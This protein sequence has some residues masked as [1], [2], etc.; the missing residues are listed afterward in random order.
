[1]IGQIISHYRVVE[2]LGGGGMG[3]VYKAEDVKLDRFVA[4]KFLPDDVAKDAQA[5]SRFQREAK[6]ASALNHPNICTIYE[7]DDQHGEAF[8]AMEFLDGLTLKHL[9]SGKPLETDVLMQLAIEIADALDAAHAKGIVHRDIKP[10]NIFVTERGHAKVLDF[11]LAKVAAASSSGKIAS[12]N[13]MTVQSDLTSPGSTLGTVAYMSPEQVRGKELDGRSDLF[14]FGV[15]LYEM[16]TGAQPFRGDTSA[17]IFEAIMNRV[18]PPPIRLNP[19]LPVKLEEIIL[20]ALEKDISLRYQHAADLKADLQRLK[21]DSESG[22]QAQASTEMPASTSSAAHSAQVGVAPVSSASAGPASSATSRASS[23]GKARLVWAIAGPLV[24]VVAAL[25][26]Y[27][28]YSRSNVVPFQNVTFTKVTENGN[29]SLAA[30]S[31]DGKYLLYVVDTH[32]QEGLWLR[33]IPSGSN[34]QVIASVAKSHFSALSFSPD[35]SYFYFTRSENGS[36]T[37]RFL[38]RAPVLGGTPEKIVADIDSEITFSPDGHKIA[39]I[40]LNDPV[41]GR[42]RLNIRSLD[43]GEERVLVDLPLVSAFVSP[44]WSPDGKTIIG[45]ATQ[46]TA[47]IGSLVAV[48][49]ASGKLTNFVDSDDHTFTQAVWMPSGKGLLV[50]ASDRD[51]GFRRYQIGSVS[52]PEGVVTPITRDTNDYRTVSISADGQLVS[53]VL[54][55]PHT[56]LYT[57]PGSGDSAHAQLISSDRPIRDFTWIADKQ[58]VIV[59]SSAMSRIDRNGV[60]LNL[61]TSGTF[62]PAS[63]A[64]CAD[65]H[66]L[67]FS[68]YGGSRN[69]LNLWRMDADGGKLKAISDGGRDET[70]VCSPDGRSVFYVEG[71]T[72]GGTVMKVSIEGGKAE[73]VSDLLVVSDI[74]VSPDGSS[75]VLLTFQNADVEPRLAVVSAASGKTTLITKFQK[76]PRS[77]L[78]FSHDGKAVVYATRE[79][80][81]DNLWLQPLDGSPG[82]QLTSFDSELISN[83]RWSFDGSELGVLRGH[84]DT[85]VV[86]MRDK[87]P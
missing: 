5:L 85:D 62:A 69:T 38:Y 57:M 36:Y 16:A 63:P 26:I 37:Y 35:G 21:R 86:L 70:P 52:Y 59:D 15:V 66:S 67:L 19:G 49:V 68:A 25:A 64:A 58:L 87:K 77:I 4:L 55:E 84:L 34:T 60:K 47:H 51:S 14:S 61:N 3:V 7:I 65:G 43:N 31:P 80:G 48:D 1:M 17:I 39:Y 13:T 20:K 54:G 44:A 9:I 46:A 28:F 74:D 76:P 78:R 22:R 56:E 45:V 71:E 72:S 41:E 8:I 12:A 40:V 33:N 82:R 27:Y 53:A 18:P 11:G 6:A 10:A 24:V 50:L 32:G 75:I 23:R 79:A 83:F 42:F 73:K 30:L 81:V 29:A 2:K